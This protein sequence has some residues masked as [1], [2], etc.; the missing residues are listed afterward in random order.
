VRQ[1]LPHALALA[2][3]L[4]SATLYFALAT[5][6]E[7]LL[8]RR[9]YVLSELFAS[10]W[11]LTYCRCLGVSEVTSPLWRREVG[12]GGLL[13][14][15][16]TPVS[17]TVESTDSGIVESG[18]YRRR[19]GQ[20]FGTALE[21]ARQAVPTPTPG[22]SEMPRNETAAGSERGDLCGIPGGMRT[23]PTPLPLDLARSNSDMAPTTLDLRRPDVVLIRQRR[24]LQRKNGDGLVGAVR[25]ELTTLVGRGKR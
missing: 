7:L 9:S 6:C 17:G 25:F 2:H 22:W 13:R 14:F 24:K 20:V 1:Q 16:T 8:L 15:P 12:V 19:G 23:S 4:E 11:F 5:F 3:I 18:V 21:G 10:V